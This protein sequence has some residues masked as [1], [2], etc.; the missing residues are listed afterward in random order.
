MHERDCCFGL[1]FE[2]V[3]TVSN[4]Q[5]LQEEQPE[6][7]R[8]VLTYAPVSKAQRTSIPV[9]QPLVQKDLHG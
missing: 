8:M 5:T 6:R 7:D 3:E 2:L 4:Q 9:V 1:P